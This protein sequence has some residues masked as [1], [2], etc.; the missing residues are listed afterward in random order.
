M[1]TNIVLRHFINNRSNLREYEDRVK[2]IPVAQELAKKAGFDVSFGVK[3]TVDRSD[4][5]DI[6]SVLEERIAKANLALPKDVFFLYD[7]KDRKTGTSFR[8][9]VFNPTFAGE[10]VI[11]ACLDQYV[12]DTPDAL[13]MIQDLAQKVLTDGALYATGSRNVPVRL[14][15]HKRNSDLRIIHELFHSLVVPFDCATL[16][17]IAQN[18]L[19]RYWHVDGTV[20]VGVTPAYAHIG[21]SSSGLQIMNTRHDAYPDLLADVTREA[22]HGNLMGCSTDYY[23][24]IRCIIESWGIAKGYV[25]SR[26][27]V[28]YDPK[29]TE[30]DELPRIEGYIRGQTRELFRTDIAPALASSLQLDRSA[31]AI[32]QF[33]PPA[34]VE[35]VRRLMLE[36]YGAGQEIDD[37]P[38]R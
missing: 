22:C 21:E 24:A 20:P 1:K 17:T 33:Y 25:A 30:A 8:Q 12:I 37:T 2:A 28:Y 38:S 34:D 5:S 9:V 19:P 13:E 27:N 15:V 3:L 7:P 14:G 29:I 23:I 4:R 36:G 32:S 11:L 10:L 31:D 6:Y 26:E 18:G 35:H 16:D